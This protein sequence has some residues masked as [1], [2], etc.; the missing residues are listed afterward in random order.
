MLRCLRRDGVLYLGCLFVCDALDLVLKGGLYLG[1]IFKVACRLHVR[2]LSVEIK[3]IS[4][5]IILVLDSECCD[6]GRYWIKRWQPAKLACLKLLQVFIPDSH[7]DISRNL[8]PLVGRIMYKMAKLTTR[9]TL[10]TMVHAARYS[11][12]VLGTAH[13]R[14]QRV[15][16][17]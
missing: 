16:Q 17:G 6:L 1:R 7:E 15:N 13:I 10:N 5:T 11:L 8:L 2:S 14:L 12:I 4:V 3:W 9:A